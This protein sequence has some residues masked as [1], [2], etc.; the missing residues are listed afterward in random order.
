MPHTKRRGRGTIGA[1]WSALVPV[2]REKHFT[3]VGSRRGDEEAPSA[4]E[5]RAVTS[6][7]V[8]VVALE[9]LADGERWR[10]GW[11]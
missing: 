6:G 9:D 10:P 8:H 4:L 2:A 7:R 1:K 11:H 3:V 5:L